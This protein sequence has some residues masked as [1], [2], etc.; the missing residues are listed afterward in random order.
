MLLE[1]SFEV[2]ADVDRVWAYLLEVEQ[3][4][5]CMPGAQL[6]EAIDD[7]NWK[8]KV[9]VKLG[10]VSLAFAGK[11]TMTERDDAA[12]RIVLEGSGMEQRGKGRASATIT[13]TAQSAANGT[14][15]EVVQDL[16]IQGQIAS[17]SRGMMKDVSAKLTKQFADCMEA[18]LRTEQPAA[19]PAA[20]PGRP[21]ERAEA[22]T[23]SASGTAPTG[24]AERVKAGEVK[25]FSLLLGALWNAVRRFVT[26]LLERRRK[27]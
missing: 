10:P 23:P 25:G 27:S 22:T 13:T 16:Q 3:V 19:A 14:R 4:A 11:V 6:T 7:R 24:P 17:M 9:T 21:E 8:G 15:V 1:N 12:H 20:A 2:P 5:Q 18:N 26:G